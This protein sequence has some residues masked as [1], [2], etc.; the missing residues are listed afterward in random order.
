MDAIRIEN[1]RSHNLAG[2]SCTI[3]LGALTVVTG[4]S[5]SGKSTLA[6]DTLYAEGQRRYVASLSTYAR[7][8]LERLPR[9]EV[10]LVSQLPPA[11]AIER[12]NRVTNARS[13]VGTATEIVDLLRLLYAHA[14]ETRC[15]DCERPVEPGDAASVADRVARRFAGRRVTVAA[16]LAKRRGEAAGALAERLAREG[17][18]RLLEDDGGVVDL[19]GLSAR[20]LERRRRGARLVMDRLAVAGDGE[21]T[22]R[23][24]EAVSR[25]YRYGDGTCCVVARDGETASFRE[26]FACDGC[27]RAFPAP[28][29]AL[30]SFN[31]PLGACEACEGFGRVPGLDRERVIPDPR[32]SLAEGAVAPFTTPSGRRAQERM[33]AACERTGV[34]VDVPV[35]DLAPEQ[36]DWL[37]TGDAGGSGRGWRGIHAFF[38]RLERKRYKVQA[39]VLIAR[40][41]RYDP[42]P[43]CSGARLREEA[44]CVRVAGR[45]IHEVSALPLDA[46]REWLDAL[47]LPSHVSQRVARVLADARA[48]VATAVEAGLHYVTLDRTVRTLSGG[49][50]QRIQLASAL[51]GTL[52]ASLYVLDEPS[53]GLHARD[54]ERLIGILRRIRDQ[55]NTVVVVEH[56]PEVIAAADHVIDLGPGA[57]RHG[58]RVIAEGPVETIRA[59]PASL[60]G[61][62][63]A[64]TLERSRR[65]PR[66]PTGRL[67]VRGACE[68]NLRDVDVD[69]PLGQLVGVSGVSGAGKTTL[70]RSVL[71][72]QLLREPERGAGRV[73]GGEALDEVVVVDPVPPVRSPRSNAATVM[74]AFDGIRRRFAETREAKARGFAAGWFSFNVAGGRCEACEGS[75]EIVVDMQFLDDV[76]MPCDA[77]DGTRYRAEVLE[78]RWRGRHIAEVLALTVDEAADLFADDRVVSERLAPLVRVGLGYLLLGQ[79]LSTLSGGEAQRLRIA[80]ALAEGKPRTLYVFDEPTT[81]LHPADIERLLA[82]FEDL[83]E[84]GASILVTEHNLD[85]LRRADHLID[86]GPGGGPEGGHVVAAGTPEEVAAVAESATGAALRAQG[87]AGAGQ[88]PQAR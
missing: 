12:R 55:G 81:G 72:G 59:E 44:R 1:A 3:P 78:V 82:C 69:V 28:V 42:C 15:P 56:A 71:V 47:V 26:R 32:R 48:R 88:T 53:V 52:T 65:R 43:D 20:E 33:L 40:Y 68:H 22:A 54:V 77:C 46:L 2:A 9:P 38:A 41:R 19:T 11:I 63:L 8:F 34:P 80:Q 87:R 29:P 14:G 18:T 57:G 70:V 21:R 62:A 35:E 50:A 66:R 49:E 83:L 67:R 45:G 4:V 10:D 64:G 37:F 58:G 23:L 86:L 61:R 39:R 31:S 27:G 16:P 60:T 79:P 25:A 30:F 75:G 73:E 5:G 17:Y 6:F 74:K 84:A 24:G 7:Q 36:R 76:R 51:G 13:T 85:L